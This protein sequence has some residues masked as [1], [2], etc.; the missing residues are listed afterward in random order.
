MRFPADDW[1]FWVA[2][3]IAAVALWAVARMVLPRGLVS[4][5]LGRPPR[6][7]RKRATL[8]MDGRP[9]DKR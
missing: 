3:V 7:A 9:L 2:T 6:G 4:R 5:L 8:T 1:Q